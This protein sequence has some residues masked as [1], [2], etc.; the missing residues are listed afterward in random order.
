MLQNPPVEN[1]I[2]NEINYFQAWRIQY[3]SGWE[4]KKKITNNCRQHE[5]VTAPNDAVTTHSPDAALTNKL[6]VKA[7][8]NTFISM[9]QQTLV[10]KKVD[11]VNFDKRPRSG[12]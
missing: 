11:V 12:E 8:T 6:D 9:D 5:N 10:P 3:M 7:I 2:I 4:S 1:D